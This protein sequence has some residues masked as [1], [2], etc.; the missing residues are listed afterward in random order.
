MK[1]H[2]AMMAGYNA[3]C[4]E[5]VYDVAAQLSDAD[6]RADRGAF[7]KS[8]HGTLN[9]LLATD[10]IWMKRFTGQGEAPN[11][12]DAILFENLGDLRDARRREDE[13]IAAYID[14]LSDDDLAGRIRYKTI[15]NPAEIEQPLAPALIHLFNHQTHHRGQVHCLLTGFDLD[16]PALDLIL[17]QRQT[18]IGLA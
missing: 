1:S 10:R 14:G 7:F 16:A 18:G 3:W 8:V 9:H 15:T 13:R 4:N 5:R 2:F 11:R 12:L 17:F 6:Y